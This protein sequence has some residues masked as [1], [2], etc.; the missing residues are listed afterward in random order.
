M[1]IPRSVAPLASQWSDAVF[2]RAARVRRQGRRPAACAHATGQISVA[3]AHYE[4]GGSAHRPLCNL[5]GHPLVGEVVFFDDGST[6]AG[7][8]LLQESVSGLDPGGRV[9]VLRRTENRGAQATKLD[10]VEACRNDWVLILDSDNTAFGSYLRALASLPRREPSTIYCSPFAFPYF[11]FAPLAGRL[12]GFDECAKLTRTGLLRR[13]FIINDGNYLVHRETYL[14]WIGPLRHLASDVADVMVANY[15]WLSN[16][17][18]LQVLPHGVYHHRVDSS[19]FWMRTADESRERVMRIFSLF[20]QG[21][22]WHEGG[23]GE[24]SRKDV[25]PP[26]AKT[27]S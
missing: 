9:R 21:V 13:V 23:A 5:L 12:L 7:F 20:E 10:A 11:S 14:R 18:C 27:R 4:R 17:G 24:I 26:A 16:G 3:V 22:R 15:L 25:E 2:C 6:E 1:T 8:A 19:S